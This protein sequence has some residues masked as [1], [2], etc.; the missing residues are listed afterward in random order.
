M[1]VTGLGSVA[2][3]LTGIS[4]DG[5]SSAGATVLVLAPT[6][7]TALPVTS[8]VS[9]A[10]VSTKVSVGGTFGQPAH[11]TLDLMYVPIDPLGCD[12]ADFTHAI[13]A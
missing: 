2:V 12:H 13:L 10:S 11:V 6:L 3:P 5:A 9:P 1:T 4:G 8:V 7:T